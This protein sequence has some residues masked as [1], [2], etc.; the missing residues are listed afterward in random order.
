MDFTLLCLIFTG[1]LSSGFAIGI[2]MSRQKDSD[3]LELTDIG[4]GDTLQDK[5]P[6]P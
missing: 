4:R 2:L 3:D 5:P 1:G 6:Y